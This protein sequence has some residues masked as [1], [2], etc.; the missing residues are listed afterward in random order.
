MYLSPFDNH[1]LGVIDLEH[2]DS[3]TRS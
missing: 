2:K 1:S 3:E